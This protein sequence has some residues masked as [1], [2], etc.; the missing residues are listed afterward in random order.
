MTDVQVDVEA[1]PAEPATAAPAVVVVDTGESNDGGGDDLDIG[2][3]LGSLTERV[4]ALEAQVASA[5][6]TAEVAEMTAEHAQETAVD[7]IE[8]AVEVAEETA[9]EAELDEIVE[10]VP[11][12][13][14]PWFARSLSEI[15]GGGNA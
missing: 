8:T 11:P 9:T 6:V 14:T 2:V 3:A 7:A 15:R 12:Q 4:T 1:P 5:Q 10:D 13:V